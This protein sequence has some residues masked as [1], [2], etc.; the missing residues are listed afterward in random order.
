MDT[1]SPRRRRRRTALKERIGRLL[2]AV[3]PV[4]TGGKERGRSSGGG[5]GY[6]TTTI[7]IRSRPSEPEPEA[8]AGPKDGER[9]AC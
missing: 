4:A 1:P 5:G 2:A 6:A 7:S 8:A 3:L 9:H